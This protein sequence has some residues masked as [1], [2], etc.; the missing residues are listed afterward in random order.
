MIEDSGV[1]SI[2]G[3][4]IDRHPLGGESASEG[5]LVILGICCSILSLKDRPDPD[6][7]LS[8]TGSKDLGDPEYVCL[9][10]CCL[11]RERNH[12]NLWQ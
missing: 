2:D 5:R 9:Y 12:E 6:S 7:G 11:A 10:I 8:L 3:G 1:E 4:S